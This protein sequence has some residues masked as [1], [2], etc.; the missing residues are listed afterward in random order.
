MARRSAPPPSRLQTLSRAALRRGTIGGERGLLILPVGLAVLRAVGKAM[1]KNEETIAL[2]KLKPGQSMLLTA[3]RPL[4][5]RE[6][7]QAKR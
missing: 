3:L 5:R 4:S 1:R 6:R 7:K 2:E